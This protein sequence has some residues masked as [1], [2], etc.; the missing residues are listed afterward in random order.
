MKE[1]N[2][3]ICFIWFIAANT[4]IFCTHYLIL[5]LYFLVFVLTLLIT[6]FIKGPSREVERSGGRQP[7]SAS[8]PQQQSVVRKVGPGA[9]LPAI[10]SNYLFQ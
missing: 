3:K 1:I 7:R 2:N 6:F 5:Q 8:R 4:H 9:P 10:P